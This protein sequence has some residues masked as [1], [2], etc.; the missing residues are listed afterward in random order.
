MAI[1]N[2]LGEMERIFGLLKTQY[3]QYGDATVRATLMT[4]MSSLKS[5][6]ANA[7]KTFYSY[8]GD[9]FISRISAMNYGLGNGQLEFGQ[10]SGNRENIYSGALSVSYSG[11]G[12]GG[13]GQPT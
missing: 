13:S 9:S 7:I 4:N 11:L 10:S 3:G 12:F 5:S 2:C 1:F 6:I 8:N